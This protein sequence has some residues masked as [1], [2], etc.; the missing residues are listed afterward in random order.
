MK[1]KLSEISITVPSFLKC[2]IC[3]LPVYNYEL[4]TQPYTYC[5]MDCLEVLILSQKNDYLHSLK[6]VKSEDH[7]MIV[8]VEQTKMF[9]SICETMHTEKDRKW[10]DAVDEYERQMSWDSV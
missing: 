5:S 10:C 8:D 4:C 7:L 9:C 3:N 6:K 1:R 2:E